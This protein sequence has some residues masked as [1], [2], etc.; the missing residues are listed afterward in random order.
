MIE[1]PREFIVYPAIDLRNGRVVRLI[2]GDPARQTVYSDDPGEV[3]NRWL[4]ESLNRTIEPPGSLPHPKGGQ[5]PGS[6]PTPWLHIVN[7]D[8]A[9]GKSNNANRHALQ[10]ILKISETYHGKI[11]FGGG[12]RTL[13]EIEE[14]LNLGV[15]R[16]L[17]GTI[18][19]QR[20]ELVFAALEHFGPQMIGAALDARDGKLFVQ[21]WTERTG[22]TTF[23]AGENLYSTGVRTVIYTNIARD[24]TGQGADIRGAEA[25]TQK[26]KLNVIASGG[27]NS[28]AEVRL[29]KEAGLAGIII[30]RALYEGTLD[31]QEALRC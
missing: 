16:V 13:E 28:I 18:A 19:I 11:Q 7:L 24:G 3:A 29:A 22:I 4:S 25:L 2:Q 12:L 1:N 26:T 8:G 5:P 21:G 15:S 6:T 20:P 27:V 10:S 9:F 31:L 23:E 14:V 30:G 17:L